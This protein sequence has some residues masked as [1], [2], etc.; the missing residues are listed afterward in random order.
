MYHKVIF[1]V[2]GEDGRLGKLTF[3]FKKIT[4]EEDYNKFW[5]FLNSMASHPNKFQEF[6]NDLQQSP[7]S[8]ILSKAELEEVNSRHKVIGVHKR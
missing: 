6:L 3:C 2:K 7:N 4:G 8:K 1:Q 5:L